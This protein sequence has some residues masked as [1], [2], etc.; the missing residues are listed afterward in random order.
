[1][2]E[3]HLDD[4]RQKR[5]AFYERLQLAHVAG[6]AFKGFPHP[7]IRNAAFNAFDKLAD[8]E[9]QAVAAHQRAYGHPTTATEVLLQACAE[10]EFPF[11][12]APEDHDHWKSWIERVYS[13]AKMPLESL[14]REFLPHAC[15]YAREGRFLMAAH[16][17]RLFVQSS[18]R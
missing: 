14:G 12:H 3:E 11:E 7:D 1:M 10:A 5:A 17:L 6:A 9:R 8:V 18:G 15:R 4:A 2:N 16:M 13:A